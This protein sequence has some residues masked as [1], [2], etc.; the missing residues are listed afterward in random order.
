MDGNISENIY[1]LDK[2]IKAAVF[3]HTYYD[4]STL[5]ARTEA[6]GEQL[7][8]CL[9][10]DLGITDIDHHL[11]L[12][13][14]GV[15]N[16]LINLSKRG[17]EYSGLIIGVSSHG[18]LEDPYGNYNEIIHAKD[19]P[20]AKNELWKHFENEIGWKDKPIIL[21]IQACRG[22]DSTPG[23]L[24]AQDV[25]DEEAPKEKF[26]VPKYP[27]LFIMNASQP[28]TVSF[29]WNDTTP[30]I[31]SLVEVLRE[32]ATTWDLQSIATHVCHNVA[33]SFEACNVDHD[34]YKCSLQMPC[35]ETTLTKKFY[36]PVKDF[37]E[38]V[39]TKEYEIEKKG[40]AMLFFYD[41][42]GSEFPTRENIEVDQHLLKETLNKLHFDIE[43]HHNKGFHQLIAILSDQSKLD[44]YDMSLVV[45][46]GYG[47][48]D[49]L[50]L[51][52]AN[53]GVND[54]WQSFLGEKDH[55]LLKKPKMFIIS[56]CPHPSDDP[57][58]E[59]EGV[60]GKFD[61][62]NIPRVPPAENVQTCRSHV[63]GVTNIPITA[64]LLIC[65]E[66][67]AGRVRYADDQYEGTPYFKYLCDALLDKD[68]QDFASALVMANRKFKK[69]MDEEYD[70][71]FEYY[72][73][74][75]IFFTTLR[76]L[77]PIIRK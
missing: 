29:R 25:G 70:D 19:M 21:F 35:F 14:Q 41:Y 53:I 13:K 27:N 42:A 40:L 17:D 36:F 8:D 55:P 50:I 3:N 38:E 52:D 57:L 26:T 67:A 60:S 56:A 24:Y 6:A 31:E 11:N 30:F 9:R 75:P 76:K 64:D 4:K 7:V 39:F 48:R 73:E 68:N 37:K 20:F 44:K 58:I 77:F 18:D 32:R 33:L 22:T 46:S 43:I 10:D 2:P 47:E 62:L 74:T 69:L 71:D 45:F 61:K 1:E 5:Q 72:R 51:P 59:I 16:A 63:E 28:G 12:T 15:L 49:E 54:I 23:V 66:S 34:H 65:F